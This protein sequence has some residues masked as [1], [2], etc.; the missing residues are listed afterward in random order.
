[1]ELNFTIV[2]NLISRYAQDL[3]FMYIHR[4][5]ETVINPRVSGVSDHLQIRHIFVS[6]P[7]FIP[8]LYKLLYSWRHLSYWF[9][10][11]PDWLYW[12]KGFIDINNLFFVLKNSI[13]TGKYMSI[14]THKKL[15]YDQVHIPKISNQSVCWGGKCFPKQQ[16]INF[17]DLILIIPNSGN[18][19]DLIW[20]SRYP[21][22]SRERKNNLFFVG[23]KWRKGGGSWS[24]WH[25][26]WWN[27]FWRK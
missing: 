20:V 8:L 14:F 5:S 10:R 1:M 19:V 18:R 13:W 6:F 11:N 21:R 22:Y 4:W 26:D 27:D 7:C 15:L 25:D 24:L 9:R 23:W 2:C 16:N 3:F 12:F 17:L